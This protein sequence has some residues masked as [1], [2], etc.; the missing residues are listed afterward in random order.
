MSNNFAIWN[1][2]DADIKI[3]Y[4]EILINKLYDEPIFEIMIIDTFN[5]NFKIFGLNSKKM[6]NGSLKEFAH[7][8]KEN[9]NRTLTFGIIL[10]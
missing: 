3:R 4:D 2:F 9:F 7:K 5:G 10:K 8:L 1:I 6:P